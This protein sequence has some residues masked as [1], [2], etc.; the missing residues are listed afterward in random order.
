[1]EEFLD[2]ESEIGNVEGTLA[3]EIMDGRKT[4]NTKNQYNLKI[5]KLQKW[6]LIKHPN[7]LNEEGTLN[8]HLLD[9]KILKNFWVICA[10]KKNKNGAYFEPIVYHASQHVSGY[11]SAIKDYYSNMGVNTSEDILKMF[12][13]FFEGY[14]RKVAKLKQ[15]GVMSVVEGKQPK[16]FI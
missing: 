6:V 5:K 16:S 15:D 13:Q 8:L 11:K 3:I 12:K 10:K 9:V 4:L 1:M 14:V 2:N 7:C